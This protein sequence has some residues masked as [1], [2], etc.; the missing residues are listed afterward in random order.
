MHNLNIENQSRCCVFLSGS[1]Q[2]IIK[3]R[4]S[5]SFSIATKIGE[6]EFI[7]I[8]HFDIFSVSGSNPGFK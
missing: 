8:N 3:E 2:G 5:R 7:S 6:I 1:L 4:F